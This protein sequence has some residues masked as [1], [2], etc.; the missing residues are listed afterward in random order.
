MKVKKSL[1]LVIAL[2]CATGIPI[3]AAPWTEYRITTSPA[4]QGGPHISGNIVVWG[5]SGGSP[6]LGADINDPGNPIYFELP[7]NP[8]DLGG[9]IVVYGYS[10]KCQKDLK[11]HNGIL[12]YDLITSSEFIVKDPCPSYL[13][14]GDWSGPSTDGKSVVYKSSCNCDNCPVYAYD[15]EWEAEF[16]ISGSQ[17]FGQPKVDEDT[18]IWLDCGDWGLSGFKISTWQRF[19]IAESGYPFDISGHLV[20][21]ERADGENYNI[22][23]VNISDPCNIVEFPICT[24][25]NEQREPAISG[26]IIVWKDNRNGNWDIYGYDISTKTEFQITDNT[27]DQQRPAISGHTVVW[28]DL[29]HGQSDIYATILYGPIVPRCTSPV[30]GDINGDCKVNFVDFALMIKNWLECNL[31]PSVACWE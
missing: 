21:L 10:K 11:Y 22:Y 9:N 16:S 24:D 30:Q 31:E 8:T 25:E 23:A 19:T 7:A 4:N 2:I 28:E 3:S 20:V 18:I 14:Y 13:G 5:D 29:R 12:G 15:L 6:I 26:N 27:S 17:V 1:I